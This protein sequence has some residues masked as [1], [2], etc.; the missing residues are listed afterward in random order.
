MK[1][2]VISNVNPNS[3]VHASLNSFESFPK[4]PDETKQ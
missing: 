4:N 1:D 3:N 2:V